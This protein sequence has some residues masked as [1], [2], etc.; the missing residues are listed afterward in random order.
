VASTGAVFSGA[1]YFQTNLSGPSLVFKTD[2]YTWRGVGNGKI[3]VANGTKLLLSTDGGV[4][5]TEV[6]DIGPDFYVSAFVG[7]TNAIAFTDGGD[8]Y[9]SY[10]FTTFVQSDTTAFGLVKG[11]LYRGISEHNGVTCFGEYG[12]DVDV[13]GPY[14]I[15]RSVDGGQTW[16]IAY[17]LTNPT[18]IRHWHTVNWLNGYGQFLATSGDTDGAM[19][20]Y[21]STDGSTWTHDTTIPSTQ[22]YRTLNVVDRDDGW[23]EWGS[24]TIAASSPAIYKANPADVSGTIVT[25]SGLPHACWGIERTGQDWWAITSV[26]L[27]DADLNANIL[28]SPDGDTW[29]TNVYWGISTTSG[30]FRSIVFL[31]GFELFTFLTSALTNIASNQ[32]ITYGIRSIKNVNATTLTASTIIVPFNGVGISSSTSNNYL[33]GVKLGV[34]TAA[35]ETPVQYS[36][37]DPLSTVKDITAS[38]TTNLHPLGRILFSGSD[39]STAASGPYIALR[40]Y[41]L[42]PSP[43]FQESAGEGGGFGIDIYR[44]GASSVARTNFTAFFIDQNGAVSINGT[45]TLDGS[46]ASSGTG[47]VTLNDDSNGDNRDFIQLLGGYQ[48]QMVKFYRNTAHSAPMVIIHSDSASATGDLLSITNDGSGASIRV[49][50]GNT[51]VFGVLDGGFIYLSN[52]FT[53]STNVLANTNSIELGVKEKLIVAAGTISI[54][55]FVNTSVSEVRYGVARIDANGADRIFR[56]PDN[57]R[58]EDGLRVYTVTNGTIR[59]VEFEVYANLYTNLIYNKTFY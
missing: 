27:G 36:G 30:G 45:F 28:M 20:W 55:N 3:Y 5:F 58:T 59:R 48:K 11:P 49:M 34:N 19:G 47:L 25:L 32:E 42:D 39:V 8:V 9:Y 7:V 13:P 24:D 21:R 41:A 37:T 50:D 51:Y 57:C 46:Q 33:G 2:A 4:I 52:N 31:P 35:P 14:R 23:I 1:S 44:C 16:A 6:S 40:G 18:D 26:E 15:F 54:S 29:S 10:D 17:S 53:F 12:T 56:V 38:I 43:P 22:P